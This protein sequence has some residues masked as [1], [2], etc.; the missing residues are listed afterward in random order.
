[1][2]KEKIV[3][4]IEEI[5]IENKEFVYDE[6]KIENRVLKV[7]GF[8]TQLRI[9]EINNELLETD[10]ISEYAAWAAVVGISDFLCGP[11]G[12]GNYTIDPRPSCQISSAPLSRCLY[13]C[14]PYLSLINANL[15]RVRIYPPCHGQNNSTC[16]NIQGPICANCGCVMLKARGCIF[17]DTSRIGTVDTIFSVL[18]TS[19]STLSFRGVELGILLSGTNTLT[20]VAYATLNSDVSKTAEDILYT[21]IRIQAPAQYHPVNT[22][23]N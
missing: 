20:S 10:P 21:Y 12:S 14:G 19:E 15:R 5:P 1:M 7:L 9:S 18:D 2:I 3:K 13:A 11:A 23:T 4:A 17:V 8:S 16:T 6:Y 22:I